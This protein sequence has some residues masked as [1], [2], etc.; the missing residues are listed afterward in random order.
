MPTEIR[1]PDIGD[2]DSVE[3]IELCVAE[4][5]AVAADDPLIVVESDKASME[6]P[7]TTDGTVVRFTVAVGDEVAEGD[8]IAE[9]EA[10]GSGATDAAGEA[11]VEAAPAEVAATEAQVDAPA[12][13]A[14]TAAAAPAADTGAGAL[15]ATPAAAPAGA[16]EPAPQPAAGTAVYASPSIRRLARAF[17]V[18]LTA[19]GGTGDKGRI[20]REDVQNFVKQRLESPAAATAGGGIPPVPAIDFSKFGETELKPL[21]R[22]RA[23]GAENLHRSWLNLPHVTNHD[24]A[25][26]TDLE[27]FRK[28]L[29]A[30][31]EQKGIKVTP[32]AF[33]IKACTVLLKEFPTVNASL[34]AEVRNFILKRYVNVG[35]AV[36]TPHGLVVPVIANADEKG[37]WELSSEILELAERARERKLKPS[38]MQGG[39]FSVSSLGAIGG[40]GFT[41]I[42][43]A[44][45]VAILG[46]GRMAVRP[47]WDGAAFQPRKMLPL[48]LSYDHRAI[49]GAE[50]GAF[51]ARLRELLGDFRQVAL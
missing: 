37:I 33:I 48:S 18:D 32:L 30:Q 36:D 8:V 50:A 25:D 4:G 22:T 46:V 2:V 13:D 24:E 51:L 10:G 35:I 45:E 5:A 27:D 17:G 16:S 12:A 21:G 41:P 20:L 40:T 34:D 44:P 15:A 39:T 31:A 29:K 43:N 47:Q 23:A 1:I 14:G 38:E 3:V 28:S 42:I 9:L 19:V 7:A 26:L 11:T 6:V 49:N